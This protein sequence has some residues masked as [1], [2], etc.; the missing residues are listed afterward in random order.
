ME[1]T[2]LTSIFYVSINSIPAMI[3][4]I[5]LHPC[6]VPLLVPTLHILVRCHGSLVIIPI[7]LCCQHYY[8]NSL[9]LKHIMHGIW[10]ILDFGLLEIKQNSFKIFRGL[11]HFLRY[12]EKNVCEQKNSKTMNGVVHSLTSAAIWVSGAMFLKLIK[13]VKI[14][15]RRGGGV[16]LD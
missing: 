8:G 7:V 3:I 2:I 6:S 14:F 12:I 11:S 13:I 4:G 1:G 16:L 9:P 5:N 15:L 10:W